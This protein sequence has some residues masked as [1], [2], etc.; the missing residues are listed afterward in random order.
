MDK[1]IR[2]GTRSSEL[3][4]W[5][6][7]TVAGQ[8]EYLGHT[9]EIVK[10]ESLGD[11]VLDKPLY[12]LGVT[13]VFTKNLD[14][15]L[16]QDKIDIAV[17][18]LKDVPTKL[19]EGIVQAAVLKRGNFNDV[20]ILRENENFFSQKKA[21][22]ATGSLRRKA[23]WLHRFP[24]HTIEGLRGNVNTRLQKLKNSE[25]D[26]AIFAAAGLKRIN[27]LPK[28]YV[29]L[30]WMI[31]APAQGVVMMA[32]KA[33]DEALLAVCKE[34]NDEETELCVTVERDFLR[35]L[36]GGCT[37][38]IGAL[39]TIRDETLKFKG[40]LFSPDGK[41]KIFFKKEVPTNH[42]S[43]LA[44]FAANY[45]LERGGKNL[46]REKI[47]IERDLQ[48]FS[49][50][51]VS[52]KQRQILSTRIG[53][54]ASD[55]ITIRHNRIKKRALNEASKTIVFTSQNAV[56]ALLHNF[57]GETLEFD[58]IFCVGR[59]TKR[60]IEK[61]IGKVTHLENNAAKL[62]DYLVKNHADKAFTFFCG[63]RRRPELPTI[64]K[65]ANVSLDEVE[66][67]QTIKSGRS[68]ENKYQ[69][70]LF[71]SPSGVESYMEANNS[72]ECTAICIGE[73]TATE[74]RKHFQKIVVSKTP[75]VEKMMEAVNEVVLPKEDK[76]AVE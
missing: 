29:N 59:R 30:D 60:L 69:A 40:V 8:L 49:T 57:S 24:E 62:A 25:W 33:E 26:G 51:H 74:A 32:C 63:S 45:I 31:P 17:H 53:V 48:I 19:P 38:P 6:A 11:L 67:Y 3:A 9:T 39:A 71:Y 15:A 2:I 65:E 56:E 37:A 52:L 43:D 20:L 46:L 54:D 75:S 66:V 13:G 4:L 76:D 10:I 22:I 16:L 61:K 50:K 27:L 1:P 34:L 35:H 55:F 14:L 70:I 47:E 28:D 44:T 12:E 21:V 68:L 64:L 7:K 72:V 73:T 18:S 58:H 36:E 41:D 42:I 5:Q 23:Q